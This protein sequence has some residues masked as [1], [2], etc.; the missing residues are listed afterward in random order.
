MEGLDLV[1]YVMEIGRAIATSGGEL[2]VYSAG[3]W[4]RGYVATYRRTLICA[5]VLRHRPP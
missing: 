5:A 3:V 2:G 1:R 4:G